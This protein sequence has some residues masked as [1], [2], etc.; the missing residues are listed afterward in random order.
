MLHIGK[1]RHFDKERKK[2]AARLKLRVEKH[3]IGLIEAINGDKGDEGKVQ[4]EGSCLASNY[5][6]RVGFELKKANPHMFMEA[7]ELAFRS[8]MK[9]MEKPYCDCLDFLETREWPA[10]WAMIQ[11]R[12]MEVR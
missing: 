5:T 11:E 10:V 4:A 12:I 3:Q 8:M 7:W 9:E 1:S 2:K 6:E